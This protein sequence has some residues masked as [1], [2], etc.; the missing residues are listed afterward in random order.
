MKIISF[1]LI[2]AFFFA[3]CKQKVLS[4]KELESKLIETMNNYLDST[5]KPGVHATVRDVAYFTEPE[6]KLYRC[7]FHVNMTYEK[8]DTTGIVAATITN[9]F[10]T[11]SRTQ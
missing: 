8:K 4:G 10:K 11:V 5:L 9:D 6:K 3:A 2:V 7:R 1:L